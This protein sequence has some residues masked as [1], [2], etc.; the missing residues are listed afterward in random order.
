MLYCANASLC[1]LHSRLIAGDRTAGDEIAA[2]T[3]AMLKPRLR[4]AFPRVAAEIIVDGIED[5][6]V[7]YVLRP[8]RFDD[9]RGVPL[10]SFLYRASWCNVAD[11]LDAQV[12]RRSREVDFLR[13]QTIQEQPITQEVADVRED[14]QRYIALMAATTRERQALR[15]WLAGESRTEVFASALGLSEL[16]LGEQRSELKR[17]KDRVLRRLKRIAFKSTIASA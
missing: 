17:F 10:E 8:G 3:L 5:A 7:D 14:L 9:A 15:L 11:A 13:C 12:R 4:R 16:S 1:Q 2:L 6:L